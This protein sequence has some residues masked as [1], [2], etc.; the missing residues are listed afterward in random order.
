MIYESNLKSIAP[1]GGFKTTVMRL[2]GDNLRASITFRRVDDVGQPHV[3]FSEV[4]EMDEMRRLARE[5]RFF[6]EAV[7]R[8]AN[9]VPR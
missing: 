3:L 6:C 9:V 7:E 2:G 1:M 5:L 8:E 4:F